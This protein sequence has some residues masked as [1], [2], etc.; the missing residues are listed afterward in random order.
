VLFQAYLRRHFG[1]KRLQLRD[2][3]GAIEEFLLSA[4][5]QKLKRLAKLA[6]T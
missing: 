5:A 4:T 3:S 6:S 1:V 2:V